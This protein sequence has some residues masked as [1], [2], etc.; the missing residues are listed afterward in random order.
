MS[1]RWVGWTAVC[2]LMALVVSLAGCAGDYKDPVPDQPYLPLTASWSGL[3]YGPDAVTRRPR[4]RRS[5][6]LWDG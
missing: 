3:R 6:L 1:K 2:A 5:F 4:R